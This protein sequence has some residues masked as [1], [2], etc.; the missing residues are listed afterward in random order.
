MHRLFR[1]LFRAAAKTI[2]FRAETWLWLILEAIPLI[3][4]LMIWQGIYAQTNILGGVQFSTVVFYYIFVFLVDMLTAAHFESWRIAE[5]REGRIDFYLTK[6]LGYLSELSI[7]HVGD[8]LMS[9]VLKLPLFVGFIVLIHLLFHPT[10]PPIQIITLLQSIPLLLGAFILQFCLSTII[11]LIGFWL[12]NAEGLDHFRWLSTSLFSGIA[13]PFAF[14]P[15]G[16]L[17]LA[18]LL[19]FKYLH[20]VPVLVLLGQQTIKAGD[21]LYLTAACFVL[22][23]ITLLLWQKARLRYSAYGG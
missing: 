14:M 12:E 3:I 17:H 6:P 23:I 2:A 15:A 13:I 19:P 1:L 9:A 4:L 16:L 5:I 11:V 21:Y 18:Q 20:S 22:G 10:L 7:R 8:K